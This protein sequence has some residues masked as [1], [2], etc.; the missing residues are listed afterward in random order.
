[1]SALTAGLTGQS[2]AGKTTV[3]RIFAKHGFYV[4][5]CDIVARKAVEPN[6]ECAKDLEQKFPQFFENGVLNRKKG[7]RCSFLRTKTFSTDTTP[8]YSRT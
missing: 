2:G 6:S 1:M 3:S 8:R 5:N 4:I 7:G